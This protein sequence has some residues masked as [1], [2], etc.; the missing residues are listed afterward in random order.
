M[1]VGSAALAV[2][3]VATESWAVNWTWTLG[4]AFA[5]TVLVPGLLATWV[6]FRL[7]GRIG[8]VRAATFHFLTPFFGVGIAALLLGEAL[9]PMDAVGVGVIMLGILAVQLAKQPAAK[10]I[11]AGD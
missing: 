4:A 7:V 2:A 5:Y 3:A 1:L 6:W 8:A 9:A 10:P 11:A